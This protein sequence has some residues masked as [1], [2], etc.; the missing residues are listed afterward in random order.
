MLI[1]FLAYLFLQSGG[2]ASNQV[3]DLNLG[4]QLAQTYKQ[5]IGIT[6]T[7]ETDAIQAYLQKIVDRLAKTLPNQ[8][9]YTVVFDPN[10]TFKSA[11]ALPG[12]QIVVGGGVLAIAEKEDEIANVLAHEIEHGELHQVAERTM[13]IQRERKASGETLKPEDYYSHYS[14]QEE[15]ACDRNGAQLEEAAG[16]SPSGM[17]TLLE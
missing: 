15:L 12:D 7:R 4:Q 5:T 3:D 9:H 1:E 2:P 6:P 16:F 10:P 13:K 14:K 8:P 17:L 11:F